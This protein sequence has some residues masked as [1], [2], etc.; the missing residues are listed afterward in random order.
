MLPTTLLPN[1]EVSR[2]AQYI[3]SEGYQK[4]RGHYVGSLSLVP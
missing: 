4:T 1:S 3:S 2:I